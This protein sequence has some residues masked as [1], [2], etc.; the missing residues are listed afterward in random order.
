M[1]SPYPKSFGWS[2][3]GHMTA[4]LLVSILGL[5]RGLSCHR[6]PKELTL[7]IEFLVDTRQ[8]DPEPA[9]PDPQPPEPEP[10][11][12]EP[13]P[14]PP[15]PDPPKKE[16]PKKEVPKKEEKK[17]PDEKKKP[18]KVSTNI[19]QRTK[20]PPP[21]KSKP[22]LPT[23]P[24][25]SAEEIAILRSMGAKPS[26]RTVIPG[27][28]ERALAVIKNALYTAWIMPPAEQR[29]RRPVEIE[30]RMDRFGNIVGRRLTQSSGSAP[31]DESALRA[32]NAVRQIRNLPSGF[33]D[34]FPAVII[35]FELE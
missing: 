17:K 19:V 23:G 26:N 6:K 10:P 3:V 24:K 18:V 13:V 35:E 9:P 22:K 1:R 14:P 5:S 32:A 28:D 34:R 33:T 11:Q 15:K 31:L 8:L 16:T 7:P 21:P 30:I 12:P 29:G 2:F 27:A 20:S 25:L 4:L